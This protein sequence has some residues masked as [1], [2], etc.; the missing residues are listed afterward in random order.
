MKNVLGKI[1]GALLFVGAAAAIWLWPD[2]KAENDD[3]GVIRPV[4]SV[5]V[6]SGASLPNLAFAGKIKANES[7]TLA[8]KQSG[9][10]QRIPVS[11]GQAV[12]AG[13][14]LAWLD[15][16]DFEDALA[17]AETAAER[18][19]VSCERKREAAKKN[20]IS[21]EEL[22]QAEALAKEADIQLALAKR[23]LSET[24]LTAPFD[25]VVADV[26]ASEL[27]M[28]DPGVAV[29]SVQDLSKVKIDVVYPETLVIVSK[30][31]EAVNGER[32][33]CESASVSFDSFPNRKF[34]VKFVEYTA[35]ADTK[36]QTY[37]ATYIMDAPDDLLLLPGMSA[38]LSV[39]GEAYRYADSPESGVTVPESA[40]GVAADGSHFCWV[41]EKAD[42]DGVFVAKRR[43]VEIGCHFKDKPLVVKS[44][45]REGERVAT[46]GT[47]V[48]TEGRKVRLLA[49]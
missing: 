20:A 45:L 38:T 29:V 26:P 25:C 39:D 49:D 46:A 2:A 18:C 17:R 14:K 35:T 34:P 19:R 42:A 11:K 5:V 4:R 8:F 47:S 23:A 10:I 15:P 32:S 33:V 3:E 28:V 16:L 1:V 30:K 7:R 6:K 37:V 48:L 31:I 21:Q 36:T 13:E 43:V 24:A 12:K 40:V 44:G 41:L 22:S 27:D 9:R